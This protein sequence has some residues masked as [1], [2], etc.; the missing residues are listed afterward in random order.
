MCD[1]YTPDMLELVINNII[2]A[3]DEVREDVCERTGSY[4][5]EKCVNYIPCTKLWK[6]AL[7]LGEIIEADTGN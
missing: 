6:A 5:C 1:D 2:D 7:V 4:P 3:I